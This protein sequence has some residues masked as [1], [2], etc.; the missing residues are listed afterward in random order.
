MAGAPRRAAF[1]DW[2]RLLAALGILCLVPLGSAITFRAATS[3]ASDAE[4]NPSSSAT[5][6]LATPPV[7]GD[8]LVAYLAVRG[9]TGTTITPPTGWTLVSRTDQGTT[10]S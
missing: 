1:P 9:G 6:T 3:T 7:A 5:V 8:F 4:V 2:T 10:I